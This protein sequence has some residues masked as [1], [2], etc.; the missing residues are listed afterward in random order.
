MFG[1]VAEILFKYAAGIDLFS[2]SENKIV[3]RPEFAP[4]LDFA[5]AKKRTAYGE[6]KISLKKDG[7]K[8]KA[9]F[10]VP[11]GLFAEFYPSGICDGLKINGNA[12][13]V[14]TDGN[15]NVLPLTLPC[16]EYEA[17]YGLK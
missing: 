13:S 3:I 16:G 2:L 12:V 9:R 15:G 7:E 5:D 4:Y 14:E 1:S 11:S 17:E 8:L 6:V 10:N